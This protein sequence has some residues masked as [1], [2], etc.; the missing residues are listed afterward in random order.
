VSVATVETQ[1]EFGEQ[2][3]TALFA[4][5]T[6]DTSDAG[7]TEAWELEAALNGGTVCGGGYTGDDCTAEVVLAN[8]E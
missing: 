1:S 2:L 8:Y 3:A 4:E 6:L 7:G 5:A